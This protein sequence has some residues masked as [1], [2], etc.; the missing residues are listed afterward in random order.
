[1]NARILILFVCV[2]AHSSI[3]QGV[4]TGV[5]GGSLRTRVGS[6]DGPFAGTNIGGQFLAGATTES[7]VPVG[8]PGPH[9]NGSIFVGTVSVTNL[10]P[11]QFIFVQ[12]VAWDSVQWGPT[13]A[14]VPTDQL[15][16]C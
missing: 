9:A 12:L 5:V 8:L 6:I 13:F 2:A 7:L 14:T 11:P 4:F 10:I 1:M 16:G 15:A 3:A